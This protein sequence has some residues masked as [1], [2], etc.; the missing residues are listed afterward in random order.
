MQVNR[1]DVHTVLVNGEIVKH[2]HKISDA[3]VKKNKAEI[4]NTVS[5][6]Q[7]EMGDEA[8]HAEMTPEIPESKV[9][10]NPYTYT[11]FRSDETHKH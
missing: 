7:S 8:W 3:A 1:G 9:M 11:E 5:Y 6:L 4:E 2:N 10:D